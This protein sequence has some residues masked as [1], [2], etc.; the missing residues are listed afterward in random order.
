MV[1]KAIL[2]NYAFHNRYF[3]GEVYKCAE[4]YLAAPFAE[5][6]E[7]IMEVKTI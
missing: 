5:R 6:S 1:D 4:R 7:R 2:L 3:I